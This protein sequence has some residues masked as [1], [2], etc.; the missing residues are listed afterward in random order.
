M[1]RIGAGMLMAFAAT[2]TAGQFNAACG[3]APRN[4]ETIQVLDEGRGA[5]DP[6]KYDR[7]WW[8]MRAVSDTQIQLWGGNSHDPSGDNSIR[9]YDVVTD[10]WKIIHPDVGDYFRNRQTTDIWEPKAYAQWGN[11][12]PAYILDNRD[13]HIQLYI[14]D[15]NEM[16]IYGVPAG[17]ISWGGVYNLG[18]EQ[19]THMWRRE[20]DWGSQGY[21]EPYSV[22]KNNENYAWAMNAAHVWVDPDGPGGDV[23][24]GLVFGGARFSSDTS[25]LFRIISSNSSDYVF[26][27]DKIKG[28]ATAPPPTGNNRNGAVAVG[29]C[30]YFFG[31]RVRGKG[32]SKAV[33]RYNTANGRWQQMAD[34][35]LASQ[36]N[37]ASFDYATNRVVVLTGSN[38]LHVLVYDLEADRWSDIT[39]EIPSLP[40]GVSQPTLA[41]AHGRYVAMARQWD[42]DGNGS[43]ESGTSFRLYRFIVAAKTYSRP[44]ITKVYGPDGKG[45]EAYN[46]WPAKANKHTSW[47]WNPVNNRYYS[48]GGDFAGSPNMQSYRQE[49]FSYEPA[50]NTWR[51]E[52]PYCVPDGEI[53]WLHPDVVGWVWDGSRKVFWFVPGM[54]PSKREFCKIGTYY[55][56]Q[57]LK[58]DPNTQKFT[59]PPQPPPEEF[60]GNKDEHNFPD[61]GSDPIYRA[62][63]VPDDDV[64]LKLGDSRRAIFDIAAGTWDVARLNTVTP[65]GI[66]EVDFRFTKLALYGR[67]VYVVD[68][69][70]EVANGERLVR[71]NLDDDRLYFVGGEHGDGNT[72]DGTDIVERYGRSL[73]S[74]PA[75]TKPQFQR[76]WVYDLVTGTWAS[77]AAIRNTASMDDPDLIGCRNY[78]GCFGVGWTI[79]AERKEMFVFGEQRSYKDPYDHFYLID[80]S[81]LPHST[82]S[83]VAPTLSRLHNKTVSPSRG[84]ARPAAPSST[85]KASAGEKPPRKH[86]A[87]APPKPP[88]SSSTPV[89]TASPPSPPPPSDNLPPRGRVVMGAGVSK[90]SN[91]PPPG[92]FREGALDAA[93]RHRQD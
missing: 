22:P 71:Y 61:L 92:R 79:S 27:L 50:S 51:Q 1:R 35:P 70:Q 9:R 63:Y 14:P 44:K 29:R 32:S 68:R 38:P 20:A 87:T 15:R 54:M 12:E 66:G 81:F 76:I 43:T 82:G 18:S 88:R 36:W 37:A 21:F 33:W 3:L 75:W 5:D 2:A 67:D 17:N 24:M 77:T 89:T 45:K 56:Y 23:G 53:S 91:L 34:M 40:A 13:N 62:L 48:A 84:K 11:P 16:L 7:G 8:S 86:R 47:T 28:G 4:V 39:S 55:R 90:G 78:N 57:V 60:P 30:A 59:R 25:S 74:Y 42:T 72:P 80:L 69:H 46:K 41:H 26:R 19:W 93:D 10:S 31:G 65:G 83:V 73:V 49:I 52:L 64:L 58:F 6:R 85:E